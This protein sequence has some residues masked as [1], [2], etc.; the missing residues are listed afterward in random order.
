L[1]PVAVEAIGQDGA[2][3]PGPDDVIEAVAAKQLAVAVLAE[4]T[5][6]QVEVLSGQLQGMSVRAIAGELSVSVG[7]VAAEQGVIAAVL[8]RLS[9][10]DGDSRRELL[11]A[12]GNL[13]F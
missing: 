13:L 9:D 5:P 1:E 3:I 8:S 11:N 6:R 2:E 7:T 12:L 4:L 10:P